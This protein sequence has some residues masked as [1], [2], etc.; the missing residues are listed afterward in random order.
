MDDSPP[1]AKIDSTQNRFLLWSHVHQRFDQYLI[2]V[3]PDDSYKVVVFNA[4]GDG[5][6]GRMLDPMCRDPANSHCVSNQPLRW[7]FQQSVL[8]NM[9]WPGEPIL[10]HDFPPGT[11]IMREILAGPY[12]QERFEL[13]MVVRLRGVC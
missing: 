9:R 7:H 1:S 10:E 3:N 11:V 4:D 12:A 8:A 2:S 6:D 5:L 13:E